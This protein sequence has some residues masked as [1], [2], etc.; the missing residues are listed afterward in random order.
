MA[1]NLTPQLVDVLWERLTRDG[2]RGTGTCTREYNNLDAAMRGAACEL[3]EPYRP[4]LAAM[5]QTVIEMLPDAPA[6]L[7][8][9]SERLYVDLALGRDQE[10]P[11]HLRGGGH[12]A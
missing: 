11:E 4:D 3:L 8:A 5:T 9:T 12:D 1:T 7:L 6:G 10:L 2:P